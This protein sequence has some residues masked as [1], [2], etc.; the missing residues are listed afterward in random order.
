MSTERPAN[1]LRG[2][3]VLILV[4][5]DKWDGP[6]FQLFFCGTD[7]FRE[8][9]PPRA[10]F[11]DTMEPVG[12]WQ[13]VVEGAIY[14]KVGAKRYRVDAGEALVTRRPDPAWILCPVGDTPVKTVWLSVKGPTALKMFNYLHIKYGPIQRFAEDSNVV[15]LARQL[16]GL[17]E[18]QAHRSAHFW[19]GKTFQWMNAWWRYAQENHVAE[20]RATRDDLKAMSLAMQTPRTV[21]GFAAQMGYSRSHLTRKLKQQWSNSPGMVLRLIRL[22]KAATLLRST[23]LSIGEVAAQVGYGTSAAFGRAFMQVYKET[24]RAY[25]HTHR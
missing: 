17:A 8:S 20:N 23:H 22:G 2:D 18:A 21:Q 24:P 11:L 14:Y 10:L 9:Q 6:H 3:K 1:G 15:R 13:Y 7:C 25:R 5:A 16:I 12:C 19:S 4:G